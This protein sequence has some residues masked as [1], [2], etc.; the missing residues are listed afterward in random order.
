MTVWL[1]APSVCYLLCSLF[2]SNAVTCFVFLFLY[3]EHL[4]LSVLLL[5]CSILFEDIVQMS[6][7]VYLMVLCRYFV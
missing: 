1:V 3:I 4:S 5:E 7:V 6:D 2:M